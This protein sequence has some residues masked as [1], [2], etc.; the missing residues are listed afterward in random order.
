MGNIGSGKSTFAKILTGLQRHESGSV[1]INNVDI[2][3]RNANDLIRNINNISDGDRVFVNVFSLC[4]RAAMSD[5]LFK[6]CFNIWPNIAECSRVR[7]TVC[8]SIA[9]CLKV[10]V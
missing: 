3:I 2:L 5:K 1:L 4:L 8:P 10:L 6:V 9:T 7:L